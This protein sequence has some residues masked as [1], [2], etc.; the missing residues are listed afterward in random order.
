MKK[1]TNNRYIVLATFVI[2]AILTACPAADKSGAGSGNADN[3]GGSKGDPV[4]GPSFQNLS[5]DVAKKKIIVFFNTDISGTPDA[6]KISLKKGS[7]TLKPT[8]DY[9]LAIESGKLVITLKVTPKES[10]QYTVELQGGA[11]KNA[12]GKDSTANTSSDKKTLTVGSIPAITEG[13]LAF[14]ANS[15]TVLT[16]AFNTNIEIVD[17][18]KIKVEVQADDAE[19][20]TAARASSMVDTTTTTQLNLTLGTAANHGNVYK[21]TVGAGAL[22]ATESNLVN[23]GALSSSQTTYSTRPILRTAPYI[24]DNKLVAPFNLSIELRDPT[25]VKVYKTPTSVTD[26]DAVPL[27]SSN[28]AV[29]STSNNL[30][31]ITLPAVATGEVYRLRLDAGAVSEE[32]KT[33]NANEAIA[34]ADITIGAAPALHTETAPYLF[35]QKIVVTF[36]APIRILEPAGIKYSFKANARAAFGADIEPADPKVVNNNQLEIPLNAPLADGQVYRIDLTDGALGGGKNQPSTGAITSG[37]ITVWLPVFTNLQP[38]FDSA[39]QLSVTFLPVDVAIVGDGS[40]I[41]VQKKD[42]KDDPETDDIDESSFRTVSSRDI[43]IDD[44]NSAKIN[45][46]LT[47]GEK[48]TPYTQVW[49]V[50]FPPNTV[51]TTPGQIPNAGS[52]T[53]L[54]S[55]KPK[56]TDLYSW[57]EVTKASG[58]NKWK[59]RYYHTS[60]VFNSKIWVMGGGGSGPERFNDVWSSPD[61]ETW[62]ESTPPGSARKITSGNN[63][64]WWTARYH[65]TSVVFDPDGRG[66]RIWVM[67]GEGDDRYND[68]WS[69]TD[70]SSWTESTPPSNASKKTAGTGKN[71]WG[72]RRGHTSVVF[73]RDGTGKKIW[74]MGGFVRDYS[75]DVWSSPDGKTWTQVNAAADWEARY[76]HTSVVF[77]R[78]GAGKKIWV[79]GGYN[80]NERND[81]WSSD[82]GQTWG[83]GTGLTHPINYARTVEYK[84]RLWNLGGFGGGT[85][86]FLSSVTPATGWT[87]EDT[88]SKPINSTQAVVFKNR[89]WLLGGR[90]DGKVTDKVWKM[91]PGTE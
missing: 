43:E 58:S 4:S 17:K 68:V 69:S 48:M 52:L 89:I 65:H 36:D 12:K 22:K 54:E 50:E 9:T 76:G 11:V 45:I 91:G 78:D 59:A 60:V 57:E 84:G 30:L 35:G 75:N 66:E 87:A 80:R 2:V 29:N 74:V 37:D 16:L 23:A 42:D 10:E 38:A 77:P 88:L 49:K 79:M 40:T 82:N 21:V 26:G 3:G 33:A 25:K 70:G 64:N 1:L 20:F 56:L 83:K 39:T 41:N 27:V 90:Y 34:P 46:I 55:E 61:G 19:G 24:L 81:V 53:T 28:V 18:A 6:S 32:S 13:S 72:A 67:G 8:T 7:A 44:E 14:Q 73:P 5:I 85:N 15:N 63:K 71:W 31:E 86:S 62:T 51:K 47:D